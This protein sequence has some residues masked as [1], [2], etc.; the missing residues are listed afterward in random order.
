MST[1]DIQPVWL[2]PY[3]EICGKLESIEQ[4]ES[5]RSIQLSSGLLR[6]ELGSAE[7]NICN[8][9]LQDEEGAHVG[10]LNIPEEDPPIRT[11]IEDQSE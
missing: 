10:I 4:D 9:E 1:N 6:Y 3:E 11:R 8:R 5:H 2:D 7:A